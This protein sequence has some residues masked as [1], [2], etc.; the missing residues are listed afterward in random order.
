MRGL[1]APQNGKYLNF[2]NILNFMYVGVVLPVFVYVYHGHSW[3]PLRPEKGFRSLETRIA[4][5]WELP[6]GCWE[7][8][9]GPLE[10]IPVFLTAEPL[11]RCMYLNFY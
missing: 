5:S 10:E 9:S 8:N 4:D 1:S 6:C 2:K 7:L 11:L 3:C